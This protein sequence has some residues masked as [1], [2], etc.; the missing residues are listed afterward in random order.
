MFFC[1]QSMVLW[2]KITDKRIIFLKYGIKYLNL[3][4]F[5]RICQY[6]C[7]IILEILKKTV[8]SKQKITTVNGVEI[9]AEKT[10]NGIF[11][12][13]KPICD[14]IGI[15]ARPQRE[16]I[17][18]DEILSSVGMLSISTGVDGKQYEMYCLPLEYVYGWIFTI[19]PKN[20]A[21]SARDGVIRYK[22]ECYDALYR[23][24]AGSLRRRLDENEAE[25]RALEEV[26][27]AILREREAKAE[28]RKAEESLAKIRASRLEAC[29]QLDIV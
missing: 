20:V 3:L 11:I 16:K 24:F 14:A 17:Q 10:E 4:G 12:P 8:M 2:N 6:L 5:S 23:H 25:I 29:P 7:G 27:A 21:E 18:E 19:N 9:Y 22:R 1:R 26:N 28:R 13:I 15:A